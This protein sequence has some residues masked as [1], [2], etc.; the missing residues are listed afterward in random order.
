MRRQP[1]LQPLTLIDAARAGDIN[2]IKALLA[3]GTDVNTTSSSAVG[4]TAL[5]YAAAYG[6]VAAVEILLRAGADAMARDCDGETPLHWS[7]SWGS[8]EI[9]GLL[10]RAGADVNAGDCDGETALHCAACCWRPDIVVALLRAGADSAA[11][12]SK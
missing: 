11:R 8:A 3:D 7:I 6:K 12:T 1:T 9:V 4:A 5:H 2:R 10:A